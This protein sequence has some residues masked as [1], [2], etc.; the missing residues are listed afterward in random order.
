MLYE[1][2][3][4]YPLADALLSVPREKLQSTFFDFLLR[5]ADPQ[6]TFFVSQG[7]GTHVLRYERLINAYL[8]FYYRVFIRPAVGSD[9]NFVPV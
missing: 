1:R 5:L 4:L 9:S 6:A 7:E 3:D 2:K 8:I